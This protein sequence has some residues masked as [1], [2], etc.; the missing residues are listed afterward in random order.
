M[1]LKFLWS[2]I[3][4]ISI[5]LPILLFHRQMDLEL[6]LNSLDLDK[7]ENHEIWLGLMD[8]NMMVHNHVVDVKII[9]KNIFRYFL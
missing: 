3:P 8:E 6:Q 2:S 7:T 4:C 5:L 9:G 1:I